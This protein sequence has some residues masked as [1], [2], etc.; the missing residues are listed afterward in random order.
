MTMSTSLISRD[1]L[2]FNKNILRKYIRECS[3]KENYIGA[4]WQ[5]KPSLAKKYGIETTLP[6]ELQS[7]RDSAFS[8]LKK[9]KVR[10]KKKE[11][12]TMISGQADFG[13]TFPVTSID[14]HWVYRAHRDL[15]IR[16]QN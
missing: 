13:K 10:G 7:A 8:K 1:R 16:L 5:V 9:R 12:S 2:A 14:T 4:P 6:D 11:P 15:R 3:T